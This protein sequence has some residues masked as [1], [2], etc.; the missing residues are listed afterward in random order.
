LERSKGEGESAQ[1]DEIIVR[2]EE[3]GKRKVLL[4]LRNSILPQEIL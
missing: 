4:F 3:E 2:K 1:E